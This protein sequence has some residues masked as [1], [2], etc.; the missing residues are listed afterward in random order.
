MLRDYLTTISKKLGTESFK[1]FL[2]RTVYIV[3]RGA[4]A[5]GSSLAIYRRRMEKGSASVAA[6]RRK[7]V[8]YAIASG[9][10]QK[11][12]PKMRKQIGFWKQQNKLDGNDVTVV[13]QW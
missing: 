10:E 5:I 1:N 3:L 12:A 13:G 11:T 9:T 6:V 4:V 2:P 7:F 8:V